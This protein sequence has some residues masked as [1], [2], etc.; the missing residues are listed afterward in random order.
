MENS[1][2]SSTPA[3]FLLKWPI[4]EA[5]YEIYRMILGLKK[6]W[7]T[8]WRVLPFPF[9]AAVAISL[10]ACNSE[11][12]PELVVT[13]VVNEQ[14]EPVVVTRVV[15]QTIQVQVTPIQK[16]EAETAVLDISFQG[17]YETLDPQLATDANALDVLENTLVGLT[18]YDVKTEAIEPSLAKNWTI[19][20][21]G[22]TW[23]FNL[24]DD[25]YWV[26]PLADDRIP[27]NSAGSMFE[28][29]RPVSAEDF[30]FAIQRACDPR[31]LTPDVFVLFIIEGCEQVHGLAEPTAGDLE[32]I[33]ARAINEQTLEIRLVE[34]ASHFLTLTSLPVLRP[35][36][37]E[38]LAEMEEE[39]AAPGTIWTNGPYAL[40]PETVAGS[41]TVLKRNPF[42]PIPFEG[43]VD[44]V[45]ILHL[46]AAD[47]FS[48]WE[49][50]QLDLSPLPPGQKEEILRRHATRAHLI[51]DQSVFYLAYNFQ[52]PVFGIPEIR[53]A[54]NNAIDR[55][56]LVEE[57]YGG[58]A[59]PM[60][61]LAPPGVIGAPAID[62]I[63]QGYSPDRA[64]QLMDNSPFGDCRLMPPITY[65]VSSSDLAL[66]QAELLRD[67]WMEEL[68]CPQELITIKQVRFG[69]LLADTRPDAGSARPDLWDLGWA[70]YYPDEQN[71]VGDVL[72][73][74]IS[75]NRQRRPCSEVDEQI[76]EANDNIPVD[77]RW[78]LYR[79]IENNFFGEN[80]LQPISPL[81]VRA[82]YLLQHGWVDF[83]PTHFGG[84]RYDQVKIDQALKELER[85]R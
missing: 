52:S 6:R 65:L 73:C 37:P 11:N 74:Q 44:Q 69:Q 77:E 38:L 18:R 58:E 29:V 54:F 49:D 36:P 81:F 8:A 55:D 10:A 31:Q 19:T 80:G 30:V 79:E 85:T 78:A 28:V 63:G 67:M 47:A 83:S 61:H 41:R 7:K 42:W 45:N 15:R 21:G 66:Q 23:R 70:S 60:R 1:Q 26:R 2:G 5:M 48:L 34:A 72:H 32:S 59:F 24:R 71:W 84:D 64:R 35:V 12:N 62:Q 51:T 33:G 46:D 27:L 16:T 9:F 76:Q 17:S 82:D 25:I 53:Q 57:V 4:G 22:R 43:N 14:G 50:R 39:W 20:D 68:G 13:E 3:L 56:R 75:E 40:S